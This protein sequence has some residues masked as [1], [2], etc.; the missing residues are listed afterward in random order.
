[1]MK[2]Y[3]MWRGES[4]HP[5][6]HGRYI[7]IHLFRLLLRLVAGRWYNATLGVGMRVRARRDQ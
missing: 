5:R 7:V 6:Q 2:M 4:A 1:M 3:K